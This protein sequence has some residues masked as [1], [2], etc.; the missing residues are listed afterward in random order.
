MDNV[1]PDCEP[2]GLNKID[3]L[4]TLFNLIFL[5]I[6]FQRGDANGDTQLDLSDAISILV[7][8]FIGESELSCQAAADATADSKLDLSDAFAILGYLFQGSGPLPAP[9]SECGPAPAPN[10]EELPCEAPGC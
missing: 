7:F 2:H 5:G 4:T 6:S 1:L 3:F 9:F 10:G 8:L